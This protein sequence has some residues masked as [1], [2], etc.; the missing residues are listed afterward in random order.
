MSAAGTLIIGGGIIGRC[1]AGFLAEGGEAVTIVDDGKVGGST[2]NAGSLHVQMQSRFMRLYPHLADKTFAQLH[3][4]PKAV[5]FWQGFAEHLGADVEL[6]ISGGLMVAED[7]EQLDFL[8]R[9]AEREQALG[10][11]VAIYET[12]QLREVAPYLG[13][14]AYGA[15]F[16]ALEGKLNPLKAN[17]AI[18]DWLKRVG[19]TVLADESAKTVQPAANGFAVRTD[20][21]ELMARRVVL[22]AGSFSGALAAQLGITIPTTAEPLHMNITE[23]AEPIIKHLVQHAER[24]ITLKQFGTGQVVIGGGWPAHLAGERGHPTVEFA[25]IVGNATLAQSIVPR[26]RDLRIIRTWAGINT[27]VDGCSVLGECGGVPGLFMAIPG[28]AGYTLSPLCARL[29]ADQMLG[30]EPG[31]DMS[32]FTPDRFAA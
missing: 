20:K 28:D 24:P 1:L 9:K 4:Y 6:K 21:R 11:D 10:L 23:A 17:P 18:A 29:L 12:A 26:I 5:R 30:R 22:A 7:R 3:M 25:S 13:E 8:A 31:E 16:C 15:E 2:A 32:Q 27:S 14:A 19:V